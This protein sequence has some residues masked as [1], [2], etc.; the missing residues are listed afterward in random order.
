MAIEVG[1]SGAKLSFDK[2]VRILL[3]GQA[4]KRVGYI[5]TGINFTEITTIC[6]GDS[7]AIGNNLGHDG[8]CK[9]NANNGLDLIIWTKH[10]TSFASFTAT[11]TNSNSGG[12]WRWRRWWG[13]RICRN[14]HPN[15]S[16]GRVS[17]KNK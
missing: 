6:S 7:Q 2:A 9:I 16:N 14:K 1:F 4:G 15:A 13:R 12:R 5:R 11:T 3:P 10:F 8:D 17:N